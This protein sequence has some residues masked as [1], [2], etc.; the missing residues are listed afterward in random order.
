M[1]QN[2]ATSLEN[3]LFR[4]ASGLLG[5]LSAAT[6]I[7]D[8][9]VLRYLYTCLEGDLCEKIREFEGMQNVR[10]CLETVCYECGNVGIKIDRLHSQFQNGPL[11]RNVTRADELCIHIVINCIL[12]WCTFG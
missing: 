1:T 10:K 12:K 5:A 2:I 8:S 4:F 9:D 3:V 11:H 6:L 7:S